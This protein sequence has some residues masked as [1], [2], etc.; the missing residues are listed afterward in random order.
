[1]SIFAPIESQLTTLSAAY[2]AVLTRDRNGQ[3]LRPM[4][5]NQ[6]GYEERRIDW[7]REGINRAIIIQPDF[8]ETGVD[9]TKWNLRAVVWQGSGHEKRTADQD[10]ATSIPFQYI[11]EHIE[12]LLMKACGYLNSIQ[13]SDLKPMPYLRQQRDKSA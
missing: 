10:F 6:T 12:S 1:M 9:T 2:Q 4:G 8:L 13:M 7:Q 5:S 3:S 11:E